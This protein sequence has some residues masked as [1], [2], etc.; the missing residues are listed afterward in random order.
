MIILQN[1]LNL[2]IAKNFFQKSFLIDLMILLKSM[3]IKD[4][5]KL[6]KLAALSKEEKEIVNVEPEKMC[7]CYDT[8]RS[9]KKEFLL[10]HLKSRR[11]MV[12][13]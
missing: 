12:L 11:E 3:V 2:L 1:I 8:E 5:Q 9:H 6:F 7:C 10:Q 4:T 13:V